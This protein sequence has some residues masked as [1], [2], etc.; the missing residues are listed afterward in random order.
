MKNNTTSCVTRPIPLL[1]LEVALERLVIWGFP[2]NIGLDQL[3]EINNNHQ[4]KKRNKTSNCQINFAFDFKSA[5]IKV[6]SRSES[7]SE[8]IIIESEFVP[9]GILSSNML[10]IEDKPKKISFL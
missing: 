2:D 7:S 4:K 9:N 6:I 10:I 5:F 1:V 8:K 3:K